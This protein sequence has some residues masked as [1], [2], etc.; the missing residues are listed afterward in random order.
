MASGWAQVVAAEGEASRLRLR[1]AEKQV[2]AQSL[3]LKQAAASNA[4]AAAVAREAAR[5]Y[6]PRVVRDAEAARARRR[7]AERQLEERFARIRQS[8]RSDVLPHDALSACWNGARRRRRGRSGRVLW[9]IVRRAYREGHRALGNASKRLWGA[10]LAVGEQQRQQREASRR[11]WRALKSAAG[12]F[13]AVTSLRKAA[14]TTSEDRAWQEATD[15]YDDSDATSLVG[16]S[17]ARAFHSQ[18]RLKAAMV[19]VARRERDAAAAEAERA[20]AAR[21]F[22]SAELEAQRCAEDVTQKRAELEEA[23]TAMAGLDEDTQRAREAALEAEATLKHVGVELEQRRKGGRGGTD[24]R[25]IIA[26]EAALS[27][28][29]EASEVWG[30]ALKERQREHTEVEGALM[31]AQTVL[32]DAERA[33][34]VTEERLC[35]YQAAADGAAREC[36][37]ARR[38]ADEGVRELQ[39]AKELALK[40][41]RSVVET[42]GLLATD[43]SEEDASVADKAERAAQE[44]W[45]ASVA[46]ASSASAAEATRLRERAETLSRDEQLLDEARADSERC[47]RVRDL[48]HAALLRA[49]DEAESSERAAEALRA[50]ATSEKFSQSYLSAEAKGEECKRWAH[51]AESIARAVGPL[52]DE[53]DRAIA[54][55]NEA[56]DAAA[57]A[58]REATK[59]RLVLE[60]AAEASAAAQRS[61]RLAVQA[62]ERLGVDVRRVAEGKLASAKELGEEAEERALAAKAAREEAAAAAEA[63]REGVNAAA[64]ASTEL[65]R[66]ST[67]AASVTAELMRMQ[68]DATQA[69][70]RVEE[71]ERSG[72]LHRVS[73]R[74]D[75][76]DALRRTAGT[77]RA[78]VDALAAELSRADAHLRETKDRDQELKQRADDA[79]A[80]FSIADD[81]RGGALTCLEEAEERVRAFSRANDADIADLRLRVP[82]LQRDAKRSTDARVEAE[83]ALAK[84]VDGATAARVVLKE[85]SD[86]PRAHALESLWLGAL[87]GASAGDDEKMSTAEG[88]VLASDQAQGWRALDRA[89]EASAATAAAEAR[90]EAEAAA[91]E[92]WQLALF[93]ARAVHAEHAHA[94][95]A[96][97]SVNADAGADVDRHAAVALALTAVRATHAALRGARDAFGRIRP[98]RLVPRKPVASFVALQP[99]P[100]RAEV[101]AALAVDVADVALLAFNKHTLLAVECS[102]KGAIQ[103]RREYEARSD[104]FFADGGVR[105][106]LQARQLRQTLQDWRAE[107]EESINFAE[108]GVSERLATCDLEC[109]K[110]RDRV[111]RCGSDTRS[112]RREWRD[113]CG[114]YAV[115][116]SQENVL[117][118]SLASKDC[119][120]ELELAFIRLQERAAALP[121]LARKE[122]A[123][124]DALAASERAWL[125]A[126]AEQPGEGES[127]ALAQGLV[128][129]AAAYWDDHLELSNIF[130]FV[131]ACVDFETELCE[132]AATAPEPEGGFVEPDKASVR[133]AHELRRLLAAHDAVT[134]QLSW[135]TAWTGRVHR[136]ERSLV[137]CVL[138]GGGVDVLLP[139]LDQLRAQRALW[140]DAHASLRSL[141]DEAESLRLG[142]VSDLGAE[143]F[144]EVAQSAA[145]AMP[146]WRATSSPLERAMAGLPVERGESSGAA[147]L[148]E[149]ADATVA[150][151]VELAVALRSKGDP[152][153]ALLA[154]RVAAGTL[155]RTEQRVCPAQPDAA[156]EVA[157]RNRDAA[158]DA[159]LAV[160]AYASVDDAADE[161]RRLVEDA[162]ATVRAAAGRRERDARAEGA[163][164]QKEMRELKAVANEA[165]LDG[166][167]MLKAVEE[168][169]L[170]EAAVRRTRAVVAALDGGN[171]A[172]LW[173]ETALAARVRQL[174]SNRQRCDQGAAEAQQAL[175]KAKRHV[176]QAKK[177]VLISRALNRE[178]ETRQSEETALE[179]EADD[180][181]AALEAAERMLAGAPERVRLAAVELM[182]A[183]TELGTL[184][185]TSLVRHEL[186]I[187]QAREVVEENM[188]VTDARLLDLSKSARDASQAAEA[189]SQ[190]RGSAEPGGV[191]TKTV[192]ANAAA[193]QLQKGKVALEAQRVRVAT[194]KEELQAKERELHMPPLEHIVAARRRVALAKEKNAS[195]QV[196]AAQA[197]EANDAAR[198]RSEAALDALAHASRRRRAIERSAGRVGRERHAVEAL[199]AAEA[200]LAAAKEQFDAAAESAKTARLQVDAPAVKRLVGPLAEAR[201]ARQ[202]LDEA[203]ATRQRALQKVQATRDTRLSACARLQDIEAVTGSVADL[204]A[205]AGEGMNIAVR[206]AEL[207][208]EGDLPSATAAAVALRSWL[209]GEDGVG[210]Q[211]REWIGVMLEAQLNG[212]MQETTRV[213]AEIVRWTEQRRAQTASAKARQARKLLA[214]LSALT[215]EREQAVVAADRETS[216]C[217]EALASLRAVEAATASELESVREDVNAWHAVGL[218]PVEKV[219]LS[220]MSLHQAVAERSADAERARGTAESVARQVKGL[221]EMSD[222]W[223]RVISESDRLA[224]E[225]EVATSLAEEQASLAERLE[226]TL[227]K[228][229]IASACRALQLSRRLDADVVVAATARQMYSAEAAVLSKHAAHGIAE[230][231]IE[232]H[233]CSRERH[234]ATAAKALASEAPTEVETAAVAIADQL[235]PYVLQCGVA[236]LWSAIQK[237]VLLKKQCAE[238]RQAEVKLNA[239]ADHARALRLLA[240]D[241]S[242]EEARA[243]CRANNYSSVA[244][245]AMQQGECLLPLLASIHRDVTHAALRKQHAAR[246]FACDAIASDVKQLA[247]AEHARSTGL[248]SEA[249][250]LRE[251]LALLR[252]NESDQRKALSTLTMEVHDI[253][254]GAEFTRCLRAVGGLEKAGLLLGA[255]NGARRQEER[256]AAAKEAAL[257]ARFCDKLAVEMAK[258]AT[259]LEIEV[260]TAGKDSEDEARERLAAHRRNLAAVRAA[261]DRVA[262]TLAAAQDAVSAAPAP[263]IDSPVSAVLALQAV[264]AE[265]DGAHAR[266]SE[267]Q[268][269]LASTVEEAAGVKAQLAEAEARSAAAERDASDA[270][271]RTAAADTLRTGAPVK[272]PPSESDCAGGYV[273]TVGEPVWLHWVAIFRENTANFA[274]RHAEKDAA[275]ARERDRRDS[276]R[277]REA[278]EA[279]QDALDRLRTGFGVTAL[280]EA[281]HTVQYAEELQL[282]LARERESRVEAQRA[283][284]GPQEVANE[285]RRALDASKERGAE[286]KEAL[287]VAGEVRDAA[288]E[289]LARSM[290]A[291]DALKQRSGTAT[292]VAQKGM[293]TAARE[294][295]ALQRKGRQS[296]EHEVEAAKARLDRQREARLYADVDRVMQTVLGLEQ[297]RVELTDHCDVVLSAA[298]EEHRIAVGELAMAEREY[299]KAR[300]DSE[301]LHVAW[302][303]ASRA[304]SDVSG[305]AERCDA[306]AAE[307]LKDREV[308]REINRLG[309]QLGAL[310]S[311]VSVERDMLRALEGTQANMMTAEDLCREEHANGLRAMRIAQARVAELVDEL[312]AAGEKVGLA[313]AN[314]AVV[315]DELEL[316]RQGTSAEVEKLADH[317]D[318][319]ERLMAQLRGRLAAINDELSKL[320]G[321]FE[322]LDAAACEAERCASDLRAKVSKQRGGR[323]ERLPPDVLKALDIARRAREAADSRM[324]SRDDRRKR[325]ASIERRLELQSDVNTTIEAE[326]AASPLARAYEAEIARRLA[327]HGI[328]GVR[329]AHAEAIEEND[330]SRAR[331]DELVAAL[332]AA[333]G[334]TEDARQ[335]V[336]AQKEKVQQ[337]EEEAKKLLALLRDEKTAVGAAAWAKEASAKAKLARERAVEREAKARAASEEAKTS[338][339]AADLSEDDRVKRAKVAE[340]ALKEA[341]L[342]RDELVA[343]I[344]TTSARVASASWAPSAAIIITSLEADRAARRAGDDALA[345]LEASREQSKRTLCARGELEQSEAT[346]RGA[347]E[348]LARAIAREEAANEACEAQMTKLRA[349]ESALATAACALRARDVARHSADAAAEEAS[350]RRAAIDALKA[351]LIEVAGEVNRA[352]SERDHVDARLTYVRAL[353]RRAER[354]AKAG[355]EALTEET[356]ARAGEAVAMSASVRKSLMALRRELLEAEEAREVARRDAESAL[357]ASRQAEARAASAQRSAS[358]AAAF[359]VQANARALEAVE[360]SSG[361]GTTLEAQALQAVRALSSAE[362]VQ[363]E[364][365]AR[366]AEA[367]KAAEHASARAVASSKDFSHARISADERAEAVE[368]G[369]ERLAE[370]RAA[371]RPHYSQLELSARKRWAELDARASEMEASVER[372]RDSLPNTAARVLGA[373]AAASDAE[374]RL[375]ACTKAFATARRESAVAQ[376]AAAA[377][378]M[379]EGV[380]RKCARAA[381]R[382]ARAAAETEGATVARAVK[383][384]MT[385]AVAVAEASL[386]YA[387][388][389]AA[390]V[391]AQAAELAAAAAAARGDTA[392]PSASGDGE[393][394]RALDCAAAEAEAAM[395]ASLKRDVAEAALAEV[396]AAFLLASRLEVAATVKTAEQDAL[397]AMF[398]AAKGGAEGHIVAGG[399]PAALRVALA[400]A[401]ADAADAAADTARDV[402]RGAAQDADAA[403]DD[404]SAAEADVARLRE[405]VCQARSAARTDAEA[406]AQARVSQREALTMADNSAEEAA[407]ASAW[408]ELANEVAAAAARSAARAA[409]LATKR[410]RARVASELSWVRV[411]AAVEVCELLEAAASAAAQRAALARLAAQHC[412]AELESLREA[413]ES[414]GLEPADATIA[415]ALPVRTVLPNEEKRDLPRAAGGDTVEAPAA[416]LPPKRRGRSANTAA[417]L[418]KQRSRFVR[419]DANSSWR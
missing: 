366:H 238:V 211:L 10:A 336:R 324:R 189:V 184:D 255:E 355:A 14:A 416:A 105:M 132:A 199:Q 271:V 330:N 213:L 23:R 350:I 217:G 351:Q 174:E 323:V 114:T 281:R 90:S 262:A 59:N 236:K 77:Q 33:A 294:L 80:E 249:S 374:A 276:T 295:D 251:R 117:E 304:L 7:E 136:T 20:A 349:D 246:G 167:A 399:A 235:N 291:V 94:Q 188:R 240:E 49:Q 356:L 347:Q 134:A 156:R 288:S 158:R 207:M 354:D 375:V 63:A 34:S 258:E 73:T 212:D 417:T 283:A 265:L 263:G 138:D 169:R 62:V 127:N 88:R 162:F 196:A 166:F 381:A 141:R 150:A 382:E 5:A 119:V 289:G 332:S 64:D 170:A 61:V 250:V 163:V 210:S 83:R 239:A 17:L 47:S 398:K 183:Q 186:A 152:L 352:Q 16:P 270:R 372:A 148:V 65:E 396:L 129:Q 278:S 43:S 418:A 410:Q 173:R 397:D 316:A 89:G 103:A 54:A 409:E 326:I 333:H 394:G 9:A 389:E 329:Y 237:E 308:V 85:M 413:V 260:D 383:V 122:M 37:Q 116:A 87:V 179:S 175:D 299:E 243:R 419:K 18:Q 197:R 81:A 192:E 284:N 72:M 208:S 225:A 35:A 370:A 216:E 221:A 123:A 318:D 142:I 108:E 70:E 223:R 380:A 36:E 120:D 160:L 50:E 373:D 53:Q 58:D 328:E 306:R 400:E 203:K 327:V 285:K 190:A 215:R 140:T 165:S 224:E 135:M 71:L 414:G 303:E 338:L 104:I 185:L 363:A 39:T 204:N 27:D 353:S 254:A 393:T 407:V 242:V 261:C 12:V 392:F 368:K 322:E 110:E 22:S 121:V 193:E 24:S 15:K 30:A 180:S 55:L 161:R 68:S 178:L 151:N 29:Q 147:A 385:A 248:A 41:M 280:N 112:A 298:E 198:L 51:Q 395:V 219:I 75:E 342:Q 76:V 2:R 137:E 133:A 42:G 38:A 335:R 361:S 84:T 144:A 78:R 95:A 359:A 226:T 146:I 8:A 113:A 320:E 259:A 181:A 168:E 319:R 344:D 115:L 337:M 159:L 345:A 106:L 339:G 99:P 21:A 11:G 232:E 220:A 46:K 343:T 206:M 247:E 267:A 369:R 252:A 231:E 256:H 286:L 406:A 128:R 379:V 390:A 182:E 171:A 191:W 25:G 358:D 176:L 201:C 297:Q 209:D 244:A 402:S 274:I 257:A 66:A 357:E 229:K 384:G 325:A 313:D 378:T 157:A 292:K 154:S 79:D 282:A 233:V 153:P 82:A 101:A 376:A 273:A 269:A 205:I 45:E 67:R 301:R 145:R 387:E 290:A 130:D 98:A 56:R 69:K 302:E 222:E 293:Q 111:A 317:R 314:R 126:L 268:L 149:V 107:L 4:A 195:E 277:L 194:L 305:E 92:V 172:G 48:A 331:A 139:L 57:E 200:D 13:G 362:V 360:E 408:S 118:G 218:Q 60:G 1:E 411:E 187:D 364:A 125:D 371:A 266:M 377:A 230:T 32:E 321:D 97:Q 228:G 3:R 93:D 214:D 91:Q 386:S 334:K 74:M 44:A 367:A 315:C 40:P 307:L 234:A 6:L 264:R 403:A 253:E 19:P 241:A 341:R 109:A 296:S 227:R 124:L 312:G 415:A 177:G 309:Q 28:A 412:A 348:A 52:R 131:R 311:K 340:E 31:G 401:L 300:L 279:L 365:A 202:A 102:S 143:T 26:A 272:Q 155:D 391:A 388:A 100:D 275:V 86:D 287:R 310:E 245:D 404:A 96:S 346:L 164:L 405:A